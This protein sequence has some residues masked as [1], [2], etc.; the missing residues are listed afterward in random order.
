MRCLL[1][2]AAAEQSKRVL[3]RQIKGQDQSQSAELGGQKDSPYACYTQ[4][5]QQ[6][7]IAAR[8]QE[9][10]GLQAEQLG[11]TALLKRS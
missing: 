11:E 7:R 8:D 2:H 5:R 6:N 1:R 10:G 3:H 4:P 9:C